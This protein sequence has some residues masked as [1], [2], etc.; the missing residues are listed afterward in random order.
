MLTEAQRK[1]L[2]RFVARG[3]L[4]AIR[5]DAFE[6]AAVDIALRKRYLRRQMSEA[7]FTPAGRSALSHTEGSAER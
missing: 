4:S 2:N 5:E 1:F 6:Q 3:W 7:H